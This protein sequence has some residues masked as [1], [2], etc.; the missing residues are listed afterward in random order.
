MVKVFTN[1]CIL[2][3]LSFNYQAVHKE[4]VLEFYMKA[5]LTEGRKIVSRVAGEDVM[6]DVETILGC[7]WIAP[8]DRS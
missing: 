1:W 8:S 4:E 7:V 2:R 5:H 6:I 3:F